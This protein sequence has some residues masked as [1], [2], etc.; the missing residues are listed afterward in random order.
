MLE[1]ARVFAHRAKTQP[2]ARSII[3]AAFTAE[4]SGLVGSAR[5][6]NHPPIDLKKAAAM[7]NLDMVGRVKKNL[8]YVGGGGTAPPFKAI[9]KQA[10]ERS[11]LEF[12]NFGDGGM[13]PSD[14]M[15]F[16][17]KKV[18]VVFLFSG[19]HEDYHRPTDTADKV[20][21]DA[22][23]EVVRV[24]AGL[25]DDF[26]H[27]PKSQYVDAADKST[28]MNPMS[29]GSG[30]G[31]QGVRRAS[32]GVIPEYGQEEEG[33]GV[34]IGGTTPE[35]PAA[36]AGL[37]AGDVVLRLGDHPTTTLM[38]LSTALAAQKPGDKVKLVYR[39]GDKERTVEITLGERKG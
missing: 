23:A 30:T 28:M 31:G 33:K 20:N 26:A 3:F 9:L 36:K 34:T 4:E 24:A 11:P 22:M 35:T 39:R 13:G 1:L 29:T 27:M 6:V 25:V 17:L 8:L 7:L 32:L 21:F 16:A 2:P 12:K 18:P 10:D 15:S 37:Q 19:V 38:E 14:H 5:F